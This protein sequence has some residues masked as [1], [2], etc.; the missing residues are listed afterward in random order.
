MATEVKLRPRDVYPELT[1]KQ[2]VA[3]LKRCGLK[4][5]GFRLPTIGELFLAGDRDGPDAVT[6]RGDPMIYSC[7]TARWITKTPR[8][9]I[10]RVIPEEDENYPEVED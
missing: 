2:V 3:W 1:K 6:S 10:A 5:L 4:V 7:Y 8:L 9:I